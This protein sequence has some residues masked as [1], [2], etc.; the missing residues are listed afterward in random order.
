MVAAMGRAVD[1]EGR[2]AGRDGE[3]RWEGCVCVEVSVQV[4]WPD[5]GEG[6]HGCKLGWGVE[7]QRTDVGDFV[8][9]KADA[10]GSCLVSRLFVRDGGKGALGAHGGIGGETHGDTYSWWFG[11]CTR[12]L[13]WLVGWWKRMW[14]EL[15]LV[16]QKLT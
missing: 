12:T 13:G 14:L 7:V 15:L 9:G 2:D 6:A 5:G 11:R 3:R 1:V 16:G 8:G 4:P 10:L